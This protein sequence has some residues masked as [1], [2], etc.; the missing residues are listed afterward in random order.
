MATKQWL[1]HCSPTMYCSHNVFETYRKIVIFWCVFDGVV[2]FSN[3]CLYNFVTAVLRNFISWLHFRNEYSQGLIS[4]D[5]HNW[6]QRVHTDGFKSNILAVRSQYVRCAQ[7]LHDCAGYMT[8]IV[9]KFCACHLRDICARFT[10]DARHI[11]ES[12]E[13]V[14]RTC[15]ARSAQQV[16]L[17]LDPSV[18]QD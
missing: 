3:L 7:Q 6:S 1:F 15:R 11:R 12:D 16:M 10:P 17:L 5:Q 14:A 13:N 9:R 18:R 8:H 4:Q 2:I